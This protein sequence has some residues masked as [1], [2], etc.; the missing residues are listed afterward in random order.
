[1]AAYI[2]IIKQLNVALYTIN[3]GKKSVK[4]IMYIINTLLGSNCKKILIQM[5]FLV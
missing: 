5:Q 1:M 4:L 2:V 3:I